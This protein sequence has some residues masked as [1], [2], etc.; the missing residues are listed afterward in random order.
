MMLLKLKLDT[1]GD[2]LTKAIEAIC[3]LVCLVNIKHFNDPSHKS[4]L[5]GV[6]CYFKIAVDLAVAAILKYL[7]ADIT[8][9]LVLSKKKMA[10]YGA[11]VRNLSSV[12]V[13]EYTSI[14]CTDKTG[15]LTM[16]QT[17][18]S[19]VINLVF[20]IHTHAL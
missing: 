3:I 9:C 2:A 12:E 8:A 6:L 4:W 18:V 20:L 13:L 10:K 17:C 16:N 1:C 5:Q 15:I 19:K 11:I 7:A 14:I